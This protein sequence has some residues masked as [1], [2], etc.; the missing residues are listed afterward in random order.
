MKKWFKVRPLWPDFKL[1]K[2][3]GTKEK[4]KEMMRGERARPSLP[5]GSFCLPCLRLRLSLALASHLLAPCNSSAPIV[6]FF[7]YQLIT[8]TLRITRTSDVTSILYFVQ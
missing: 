3:L 5:R 8:I 1:L 4:E 2:L 7:F 6:S